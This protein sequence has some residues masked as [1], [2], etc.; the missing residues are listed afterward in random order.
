MF[1]MTVDDILV[2]EQNGLSWPDSIQDTPIHAATTIYDVTIKE[3]LED[4]PQLLSK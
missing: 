2:N 1:E 3:S 4:I